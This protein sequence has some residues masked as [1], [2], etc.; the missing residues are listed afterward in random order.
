MRGHI[1]TPERAAKGDLHITMDAAGFMAKAS[2]ADAS[3]L[4]KLHE[5]RVVG[6]KHIEAAA[7]YVLWQYAFQKPFYAE[8]RKAY[9]LEIAG[10]MAHGD[11]AEGNYRKLLRKLPRDDQ[12]YIEAALTRDWSDGAE[13]LTAQFVRAFDALHAAVRQVEDGGPDKE[14]IPK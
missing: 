2:A 14:S 7:T 9:M 13:A 11:N 6:W 3:I 4:G 12:E 1:I 8:P 5:R 10:G